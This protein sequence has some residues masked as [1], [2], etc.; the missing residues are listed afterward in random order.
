MQS[1]KS[2]LSAPAPAEEFDPAAE[3]SIVAAQNSAITPTQADEVLA[4]GIDIGRLEAL[5]F[6][7]TI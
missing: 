7:Q 4:A 5:T 3:A 6:V 2:I 1:E